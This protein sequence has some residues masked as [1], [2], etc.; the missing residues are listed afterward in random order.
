MRAWFWPIGSIMCKHDVIHK[1]GSIHNVGYTA[2]SSEE[3][4]ATATGNMYRK[5]G[6]IL[7]RYLRYK[8]DRQTETDRDADCNTSP[9]YYTGGLVIINIA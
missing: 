3:V 5:F 7:T 4:R 9:T 8:A 1:I 2:L 6:E